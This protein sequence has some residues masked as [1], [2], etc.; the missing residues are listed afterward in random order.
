M[1]SRVRRERRQHDTTSRMCMMRR[2]PPFRAYFEFEGTSAYALHGIRRVGR[3]RR[4]RAPVR[5]FRGSSAVS[6]ADAGCIG[7]GKAGTAALLM[8]TL[9]GPGELV[10]G[11]MKSLVTNARSSSRVTRPASASKMHS[12]RTQEIASS[13]TSPCPNGA[14]TSH[15]SRRR[16]PR[17]MM[18]RRHRNNMRSDTGSRVLPIKRF[19]CRKA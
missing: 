13:A 9:F 10:G 6:G 5:I 4:R 12:G 16:A 11:G 1:L 18:A 8:T 15:F 3:S 7:A 17:T 19:A 14:A 2:P